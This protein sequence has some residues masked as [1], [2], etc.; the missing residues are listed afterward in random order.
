MEQRRRER[1]S[2]ERLDRELESVA[3]QIHERLSAVS[4]D[5][6]MA[7]LQRPEATGR[8]EEMVLNGVYLVSHEG[9]ET[10]HVTAAGLRVAFADL[11]LTLEETG[12]WPAYNFVPGTIG[13]A[14]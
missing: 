2:E 3:E 13:A 14:W 8:L 5:G 12:P 4:A 9:E 1:D 10:F 6:L 7:P 11:G